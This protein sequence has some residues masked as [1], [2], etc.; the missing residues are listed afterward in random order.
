VDIVAFEAVQRPNPGERPVTT[1]LVMGTG[2]PV[3]PPQRPMRSPEV[4][5][6]WGQFD[7]EGE[8]QE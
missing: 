8:P 1:E 7:D 2:E 6:D 5:E 4:E 3:E